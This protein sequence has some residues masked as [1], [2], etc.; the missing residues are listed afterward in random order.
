MLFNLDA[1]EPATASIV[2]KMD[3]VIEPLAAA[4]AAIILVEARSTVTV[5]A[6]APEIFF[7]RERDIEATGA[8]VA[9]MSLPD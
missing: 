6:A 3:R 2:L 7:A 4:V 9:R 1:A 8:E 5:A